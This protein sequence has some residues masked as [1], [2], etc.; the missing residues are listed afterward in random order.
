MAFLEYDN[1]KENIGRSVANDPLSIN[2]SKSQLNMAPPIETKTPLED[3][4]LYARFLALNDGVTERSPEV[5]AMEDEALDARF[6]ALNDGVTERSPEVEAMEDEALEARFLDLEARFL[7]LNDGVKAR[8][9]E[10]EAMEDEAL[11]ARLLALNDG[12][13]ERNSE[14][15]AMELEYLENNPALEAHF[16]DLETRYLALNDGIKEGNPEV[17]AMEQ[18]YLKEEA[19]MV[20][21]LKLIEESDHEVDLEMENQASDSKGLSLDSLQGMKKSD[22]I[23]AIKNRSVWEKAKAVIFLVDYN[24]DGQK[25]T[26]AIPFKS[27]GKMKSEMKRLKSEKLHPNNKTGGGFVK[28]EDL[29]AKVELLLGGLKPGNLQSKGQAL[30]NKINIPLEV[31]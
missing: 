30:F 25:M 23:S 16:L 9:P 21:F 29:S 3:E 6:L 20:R 28:I 26:I 18:E 13:K 24:L 27:L 12:V 10:V 8:S 5:E 14:V 11:E 1:S 31:N 7:A 2:K 22:Y 4:A 15:E 19:L 17:E